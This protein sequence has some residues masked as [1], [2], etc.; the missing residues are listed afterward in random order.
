MTSGSEYVVIAARRPVAVA[1]QAILH[2]WTIQGLVNPCRVVDLDSVRDG[3]AA[4]PATVLGLDDRFGV[5][6]QQDLAN[7]PSRRVRVAVVG[8]VDEEESAVAQD[9]AMGVLGALQS[10]AP[11]AQFTQLCVSAGS[12]GAEWQRRSLVMFGWHNLA[13]SPEESSAPGRAAAPLR[14]S[15]SDPRWYMLLAGTL[16][17]LLGLWPGQKEGPFD[18][19]TTPSGQLVTPIR[20]YSRSLSSGSVQHALGERL[21]T[22]SER[23][24]TPRVDSGFALAVDDEAPRAVGMAERLFQKHPDMMPRVRH[25]TA[26]PRPKQIGAWQAILNFLNF[27]GDALLKAPGQLVAAVTHAARKA[28][29]NTV[30]NA[31]FGG[32]DSGYAVVVRGVR[33][34]GSS[35]TWAEYESQLES[36]IKRTVADS[37]ELPPVPQKP[38]LWHDFVDGG[39]TL[40]DAGT[41]SPDLAPWTQGTQRAIVATTARVAPSPHDPFT[42]P[43]S[44]AAFLPNWEIQPG[45]DIA[46]GRLFDRLDYLARTQPH[47][48]QAITT[49]R[50]RLRQW[51]ETARASY[52]GHV[53]RR[54]GDAHRALLVEVDELTEKVGRLSAQPEV[55]ADVE[56]LQDDLAMR[57]RV[58]SGVAVSLLAILVALTALSVIGWPWL[59]LGVVLLVSGWLSAGALMHMRSSAAVYAAVYRLERA[60]TELEDA[61]RHRIEALEDLR[62][63]SRAYRQYLDWARVLGAFLHAPHG[64]PS[65]ATERSV[66]VGQGLPLNNAIGVAKPDP[67]AVDEVANRWR[68]RLFPVGWL[69][70]PWNEFRA[71]LPASLGAMRHQLAGDQTLLAHDPLIDGVPA[72]S[73]WSRAMAEHAASRSMSPTIQGQIAQLTLADA[74]ARDT[75]LSRVLVRDARDGTAAEVRRTDFV[76]G[77]DTDQAGQDSFQ[78]GMFADETS[79]LDVRNV[80]DAIRQVDA[81]GLD[82]ALVVVQVGGAY[83]VTQLAGAP[84]DAVEAPRIESTGDFV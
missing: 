24:P 68:G 11:G 22:V 34:D 35:A 40:L 73:R 84:I 18:G 42:L 8:V 2:D 54:L 16:T 76:A 1:L 20:A 21:I 71:T 14:R 72:L 7:T 27:V 74:D 69:S 41:R 46:V 10:T 52:S 43:P 67:D 36:V 81:A 23:Y 70:D 64:N 59:L 15:T 25:A 58:L 56:Q 28:V 13:V 57:V 50:N 83:P 29:A 75:L 30:Q 66:H 37:S 49:E 55:P 47:L 48:G 62:L 19:L 39:L 4:I 17:S 38:Q 32:S 26:P 9:Q 6:L 60:S 82:V 45:D 78:S 65:E 5:A 63:V 61:Q 31:V 77:L 51:A 3:E 12:P 33:A 79:V 80:R 44:L 53:G